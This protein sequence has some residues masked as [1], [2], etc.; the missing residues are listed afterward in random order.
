[1]NRQ[2]LKQR[3]EFAQQDLNVVMYYIDNYPEELPK[4]EGKLTGALSCLI[5][6]LEQVNEEM[7]K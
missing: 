4:I 1:M 3:V 7:N 6:A 2:L 5:D